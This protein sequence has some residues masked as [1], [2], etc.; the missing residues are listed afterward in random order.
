MVRGVALALLLA[1]CGA[2]QPVPKPTDAP[3]RYHGQ[4]LSFP[5]GT[6]DTLVPDGVAMGP[7]ARLVPDAKPADSARYVIDL[8]R[9]YT[10]QDGP[11]GFGLGATFYP[12]DAVRTELGDGYR[13]Y[14]NPP[15]RAERA[16][17]CAALLRTLPFAAMQ[18]R[19]EPAA[20][21]ARALIGEAE[22]YLR[23]AKGG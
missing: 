19:E 5:P 4:V 17:N 7:W 9:R 2:E 11:N 22:A 23:K 14:C 1:G 3:F 20:A 18:F 15:V 21:T 13:M 8:G 10:G 16:F 12:A 6:A